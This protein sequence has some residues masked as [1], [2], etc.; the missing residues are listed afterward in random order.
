MGFLRVSTSAYSAHALG[1]NDEK[2]RILAFIRP[3]CIAITLG[4]TFILFQKMIGNFALSILNPSE[5]IKN[6]ADKYF[7]ILIWGAPLVLGNYVIL[8]WLM[9]QAKLKESLF[10]QITTNV[11]NIV[12]DLLLVQVFN[13]NVGGVAVATLISQI[14]GFGIGCILMITCGNFNFRNLTKNVVFNK[15]AF[16]SIMKCNT[17]LQIL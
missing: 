12:L 7:S 14:I 1:T 4:L 9:G 3:M 11:V 16:K 2:D 17:D 5:D 15:E 10:M 8:G 6:L 13:Y